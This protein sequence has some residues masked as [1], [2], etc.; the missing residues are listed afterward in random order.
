ME[1]TE[2][3]GCVPADHH[4]TERHTGA[5]K[6]ADPQRTAEWGAH[7]LITLRVRRS[8]TATAASSKVCNKVYTALL[9]FGAKRYRVS[10]AFLLLL[11]SC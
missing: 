9:Q 5:G 11:F 10:A 7:L 8:N 3:A 4:S 6:Q 1:G 2:V